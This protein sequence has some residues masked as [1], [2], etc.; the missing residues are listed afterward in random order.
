MF[1]DEDVLLAFS[2]RKTTAVLTR[3][4]QRGKQSLLLHDGVSFIAVEQMTRNRC[5]ECMQ[6]SNPSIEKEMMAIVSLPEKWQVP[7]LPKYPLLT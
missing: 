5:N 3:V 2:L 4:P 1:I 7:V 6:K